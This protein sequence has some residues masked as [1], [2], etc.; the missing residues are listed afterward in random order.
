MARM[1]AIWPLILAFA[2]AG[3]GGC[4]PGY[5]NER[6]F[7]PGAVTPRSAWRA[8]GQLKDSA[9]ALDGDIL[10]AAVS[11]PYYNDAVL[12]IDLGEVCLL[13]MIAIDH[14][15]EEMGYCRRVAVETSIDGKSFARHAEAPGT[16]K[17]TIISMVT[18]A[19]ARYVRLKVIAQGGRPWSVAEIHIQ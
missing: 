19:M 6:Q 12:D 1:R 3:A 4:G 5:V 9:K 13:N 11:E 15:P 14:G 10:T 17:I 7:A 16:R 8:S 2:A 18:P